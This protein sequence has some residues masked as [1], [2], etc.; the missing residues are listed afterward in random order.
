MGV[1][2]HLWE[3]YKENG[4]ELTLHR[5][6]ASRLGSH[7]D[8]ADAT[9]VA[10]FMTEMEKYLSD[11]DMFLLMLS[12]GLGGMFETESSFIGLL[13]REE[14]LQSRIVDLLL[15]KLS[16]VAAEADTE[17]ASLERNLPKLILRE[18]RWIDHINDARELVEKLICALPAFPVELQRDMIYILPE[19]A[20]DA[21]SH[22]VIDSLLELIRGE[23]QLVVCCIEA[24]GNFNVQTEQ[25]NEVIEC[26]LAR[27]DSSPI[28]D[29]PAIVKYLVQ[30]APGAD[31]EL[32]AMSLREKLSATLSFTASNH[33]TELHRRSTN[34]GSMDTDGPSGNE[35][36]LILN[37]IVQGCYF[38][39]DLMKVFLNIIKKSSRE[40]SPLKL[41]DVWVMIAGYSIPRDRVSVEKL[42][43]QKAASMVL[44]RTLLIQS[45]VGHGNALK[46]F[47]SSLLQLG[48]LLLTQTTQYCRDLGSLFFEIVFEEFSL[49]SSDSSTES[50]LYQSEV[51]WAGCM[52]KEL[53]V[54]AR[55]CNSLLVA[56]LSQV[57]WG[58]ACPR[59]KLSSILR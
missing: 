45:I 58:T 59:I 9:A 40:D 51:R 28:Q 13:L 15:E 52:G 11:V 31:V 22:I 35:E 48:G 39:D 53:S 47:F 21:D 4:C 24:L 30:E 44:S 8:A 36:A 1:F 50:A 17:S 2:K 6:V 5:T 23:A 26:V 38:R 27:L 54:C 7:V 37:S 41:L 56:R 25:T 14:V 18:L 12:V 29:L 55:A 10:A 33:P 32:I 57:F 46:A 16:E 42:V 19:I 43:K 20:S 3:I 34:G 49:R